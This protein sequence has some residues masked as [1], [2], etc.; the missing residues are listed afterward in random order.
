MGLLQYREV[1]WDDLGGDAQPPTMS[2]REFLVWC[3]AVLVVFA[4]ILF[5]LP[6]RDLLL[7]PDELVAKYP[8]NYA[9]LNRCD[10]GCEQKVNTSY[11]A[12][13]RQCSGLTALF[14]DDRHPYLLF[15]RLAVDDRASALGCPGFPQDLRSLRSGARQAGQNS[16]LLEEKDRGEREQRML[17]EEA[18]KVMRYE[19]SLAE[20][21]LL[22]FVSRIVQDPADP[23]TM[24]LTLVP[25]WDDLPESQRAQ[26]QDVLW[27]KWA[28]IYSPADPAQSRVIFKA[29]E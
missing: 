29:Q 23:G 8:R 28:L 21:G 5:L 22:Q 27:Q 6:L 12:L 10:M 18:Q 17:D 19:Q 11:L 15:W 26:M 13:Q 14:S 20:G 2:W 25:A 24:I 3:S 4:L 1:D 9:W 16:K 7:S